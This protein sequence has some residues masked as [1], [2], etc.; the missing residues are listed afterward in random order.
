ME[1]KRPYKTSKGYVMEYCPDHPRADKR[2]YVFSH[3][4]AYEN[5]IGTRVPEGYAVHHINGIKTDNDPSNLTMMPH[6]EHTILHHLGRKA[7]KETREKISA[8]SKERLSIPS[9]HPRFRPL[10]VESMKADRASGMTVKEVCQK[11]GI[12]RATYYDKITNYRRE[13]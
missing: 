3:I 1:S 12:C 7:S 5:H 2:G 11:Y 9:N 4:V 8:R 10:D 6:G 13:K